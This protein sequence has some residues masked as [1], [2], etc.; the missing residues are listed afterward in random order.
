MGT[1]SKRGFEGLPDRQ[2]QSQVYYEGIARGPFR[3]KT[4]DA[5]FAALDDVPCSS[6]CFTN[7]S[8]AAVGVRRG[9]AGV[10]ITLPDGTGKVFDVVDNAQELQVN[11]QDANV[12]M[13]VTYECGGE[14]IAP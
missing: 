7:T 3:S 6:V 12:N 8:G 4:T 2:K 11:N 9:G 5:T 13:T 10:V 1:H 14:H